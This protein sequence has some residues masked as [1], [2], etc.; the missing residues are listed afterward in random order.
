M[1]PRDEPEAAS[2]LQTRLEAE[3]VTIHTQVRL[4][5]VDVQGR[6]KIVLFEGPGGPSEIEGDEFLMAVGREPIISHFARI[7]G[8]IGLIA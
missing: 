7:S 2:V 6:T 5:R 3:G 4:V 1:L 8:T